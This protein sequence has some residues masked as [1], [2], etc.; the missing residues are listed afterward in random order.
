MIRTRSALVALALLASACGEQAPTILEVALVNDTNVETG[1]YEVQAVVVDDDPLGDVTLLYDTGRAGPIEARVM[2]RV[3]EEFGDESA[4]FS[5]TVSGQPL[6]TVVEYAVEACDI[7]GFC[8]LDP[9]GFPEEA[10]VFIVGKLPSNPSIERVE[11]DTGPSSGGTRVEIH[12]ADFRPGAVARFGGVEAGVTEYVRPDLVVA[13][14]PPHE[15]VT[16]DVDVTNPDEVRATLPDAFT[17]FPAPR[18]DVID[19]NSGPSAGGTPVTVT[20]EFFYE[21][22]RVF[23][24]DVPCRELV[25]TDERVA[26]CLTPPGRPGPVDVAVRHPELGFDVVEDGYAYIPPPRVDGVEPGRGSDL[27][28]TTVVIVG[29]DFDSGVTVTIGGSPCD[30][31]EQTG[32]QI[33]CVTSPGAPGVADVVVTNG[34]GQDDVFIGGFNY[35][36]PPVVVRVDPSTGP[37][38]GGIEA[39]LFGAGFTEDTEVFFGD[40]LATV[41]DVEGTI[42]MRVLVPA[43]SL[44]TFPAP[45]AGLAPVDVRVLR[46]DEG[47]PR[48][49]TLADGFTYFWPPEPELVTPGSG[50]TAGGTSV[51]ISGRFLREFPPGEFI[52]LFGDEPALD[53]QILASDAVRVTTPPGPA[54]FVD[55]SVQNFEGSIGILADGFEYIPPPEVIRVEPFDGPTFGGERVLIIGNNFR[56]GAQVDFDG[57]P[58]GNVTFIDSTQLQCTTP[59]GEEGFADVQVTNPDGQFDVLEQGYEYLGLVVVPGVGLPAGFTR[60]RVLAAGMQPTATFTFGGVVATD[61]QVLS[62]REAV[63]QT[64]PNVRGDVEVSFQNPNGTGENGEDAF[65][66]REL[67]DR[68]ADRLDHNGENSNHVEVGDVDLDG[69]LDLVVANGTPG[70]PETDHVYLNEGAGSFDRVD[71][72]GLDVSNKATFGDLNGDALPDLV[73]AVS[74][75][76]SGGALLMENQGN[77]NYTLRNTPGAVNGAFDAQL[78]DLVGDARDDLLIMAIGCSDGEDIDCDDITVGQDGLFEASGNGFT[79]RSSLVPHDVGLVHDH[80]FVAIDLE[81]DGDND[82][83]TFV[84]NDNFGGFGNNRH[85]ILRNRV[86]EGQGF[87]EETA[88]FSG[89]VG[90]V[91]GI[92]A[93]DVDG[94]GRVD[95]VAPACDPPFDSSELIFLNVNGTLQQ[96]LGA[97]PS[98]S[99]DC[100]VGVHLV[101][102]D[103]DGDNDVVYVGD[104]GF[105]L[106]VKVYVNRGDGTFVD[107]SAAVPSFA[108]TFLRGAEAASGDIDGDG[109]TD[110]IVVSVS[111]TLNATG[112]LHLLMLE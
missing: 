84:D 91:F 41:L 47:T 20:G 73:V 81:P 44:P 31:V 92:D 14:T 54:G 49:D 90:D 18:I 28:G 85:R 63:C 83:V 105:S 50:P 55:V 37:I 27:G 103:K 76:G 72:P 82:I 6:G 111:P 101:D 77:G 10:H 70:G 4:R 78:V 11:P 99:D 15:P 75:F 74:G 69:D 45:A 57:R 51:V 35:L 52:V 87:V 107:A 59:P 5:G 100:D 48:E 23:F 97:M 89:L 98:V 96:S 12:G 94:D 16:V 93:G 36:G 34:D 60:V 43:S 66:Y 108:N 64:P 17:Y 110:L 7:H 13:I 33:V 95:V 65:S 68:T 39:V 67:F 42:S 88:P 24:D 32:E 8:A 25:I 109:D 38:A 102:I 61:C 112:A 104:R 21:G 29:E 79:N 3:A 58:C 80:K 56:E 106:N 53:I 26:N 71:L 86:D 46:I 19:P 2:R 62:D 40:A 1:P 9:P 22:S 30:I